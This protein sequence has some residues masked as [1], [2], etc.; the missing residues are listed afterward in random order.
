MSWCQ[1]DRTV[2]KELFANK[3][4]GLRV[5]TGECGKA[6]DPL[7]IKMSIVTI[8]K[9]GL[10]SFTLFSLIPVKLIASSYKGSIA[11]SFTLCCTMR[12]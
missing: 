5:T 6:R 11:E 8:T 3:L 1:K 2:I 4:S 9:N 10:I 12:L 7:K